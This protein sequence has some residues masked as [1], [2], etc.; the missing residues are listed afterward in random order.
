MK[1]NE[2]VNESMTAGSVATVSQPL[3]G[4]IKRNPT[5]KKKKPAAKKNDK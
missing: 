4:M 3:G 5:S 1:M 2:I